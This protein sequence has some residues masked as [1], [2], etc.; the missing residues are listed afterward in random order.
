VPAA[1]SRGLRDPNDVEND[2][3][4][5]I[6]EPEDEEPLLDAGLA[7][8]SMKGSLLDVFGGAGGD[9][10]AEGDDGGLLPAS[11]AG[12]L[13][14]PPLFGGLFGGMPSGIASAANALAS[15][16]AAGPPAD[17]EPAAG[18]D[19]KAG[20]RRG[21]GGLGGMRMTMVVGH[22][23]PSGV[24]GASGEPEMVMKVFERS[25]GGPEGSAGKG[26]SGD[27]KEA[28]AAAEALAEAEKEI[29]GSVVRALGRGGEGARG[30]P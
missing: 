5:N 28:E 7:P 18:G 2:P 29:F 1:A 8:T 23:G 19:A 10:D 3:E 25:F 21:A 4:P 30:G 20:G 9:E 14:L 12:L 27:S 13:P 6:D 16:I 17:G 24:K 22:M 26:M 15:A 11:L